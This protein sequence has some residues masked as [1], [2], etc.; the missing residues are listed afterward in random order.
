MLELRGAP[1]L[2]EFKSEKLLNIL[3][4]AVPSVTGVY[5]EFMHFTSLDGTLSQDEQAILDKALQ[6]GPSE[7]THDLEGTLFLVVPRPGTISPWSSKATDILHNCGLHLVNRIE[8]G[9]AYYINTSSVVEE[10]D[11]K[12]LADLLHD[13]MTEAVFSSMGGAELLFTQSEPAPFRTV[14]I[15]EGGKD[16]LAC[17]NNDWGLALA[18]DEIDYLVENFK[19]LGR[20]PTDVEL[21]MFAQAN[22][23]HCRHK[24]FNADWVIDGKQADKSLF[25]MIKNTNELS[26][27]DVLS[28]YK[29]NASVIKGHK[30]GRFFP[31]AGTNKYAYHQEDIHILMKVETHNHPTAIAPHAGAATGS[32]GEIRD[33]GATGIGSKPKAGLTGFTVSNLK[34]PGWQQPWEVDYGKPERIVSA[35][36]IMIEGPLGGAA[37]NNEFGRPNLTGYFRTYEQESDGVAGQEVRGYHKPIMLAGGLGNIRGEHVEKKEFPVGAKLIVLGGPAML[38][39]LGGGAASSMTSGSSSADLDFASVQL[40]LIHISAPTRPY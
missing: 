35:L 31:K 22:S 32:G 18:D 28:A 39:G 3:Q 16:A 2:S 14:N 33:E 36:D 4:N 10:A 40:S 20:N 25:K 27:Q 30:A 17:A 8:R 13:R 37:F 29:D 19:S 9:V 11:K 15:L 12:V 38:I 6:Y 26:G 34:I 1:A 21:M 7:S 24:I 5:A 23:E